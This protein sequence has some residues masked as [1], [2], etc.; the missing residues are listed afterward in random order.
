M[1]D[2][3][4][5][6]RGARDYD[7][8]DVVEVDSVTAGLIGREQ[9]CMEIA[10]LVDD[11]RG[12]RSGALVVR[13][14]PGIGKSA[15]LDYAGGLAAEMIVLRAV[16]VDSES[17]LAFAGLFGLVR[18]VLDLLD[19]LVETQARALAGALGM[20]A[21]PGI[22]RFLVGAAA[23]SLLAA[24]AEER[25]VLCL[26][27]DA[28]WLDRPSVDALSFA[29]RRLGADPIAMMFGAREGELRR[30]EGAGLPELVLTGLDHAAAGSLLCRHPREISPGVRDR[31]VAEA[32]G[33]PLALLELPS[34]LNDG[35][36]TGQESLPD[37]IPLTPRLEAL[38]RRRIE[39]LPPASQTAL[40]IA[41]ADNTGD[42]T[43]VSR[44]AGE[45]EL[46]TDALDPA[47]R[48]GLLST[49]E[50]TIAFRH[51][52]VRAAAYDAAALSERLRVH[53]ALAR[54]LSGDEDADRR[55]WHQAMATVTGNE[56]VA[57]AL[58]ASARRAQLR[59]GHASAATAFERAAALTLDDSR[60][61]PRLAA[62]AQAAWD[63]GQANRARELIARALPGAGGML[64]A[65]LLHLRGVI[66]P[67]RGSTRDGVRTLTD[68]AGASTDPS[69]TLEVLHDAIDSALDIGD[70]S[71]VRKLGE[72]A[73]GLPA[74]TPR[75][76]FNKTSVIAFGA[77]S[78]GHLR[79]AR[80]VFGEAL[81]L[82]RGMDDPAGQ[83][84]ASHV[85]SLAIELGAGLSFATRAVELARSQGLMCLLP[86]AL[87]QQAAE[88]A[89]NSRFDEA[90]AAAEE[91]Y[92]LSVE[93]GQSLEVFLFETMARVE[94][95]CGRE[96]DAREHAQ[97]VI[98]LAQQDRA[99]S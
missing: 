40:L 12:G 81:E 7:L 63:A 38:F 96:A 52:L 54:V 70:H 28:H 3:T 82:A 89:R 8:E 41:A 35:Q 84:W 16:G 74:R 88:L 49:G 51:P 73:A 90:Y 78:A 75:D 53:A 23:L 60:R 69:F 10:A 80:E 64:R 72:L 43:A 94:A 58:D 14:E 61:G 19:R 39:Q 29:A 47:E 36:L 9:E 67:R 79:R 98:G 44:A 32:V 5:S 76:A 15:L 59:G 68:A 21:S 87:D 93:L 30:F 26:V 83:L 42:L 85:A 48:A 4:G 99:I 66:E 33:N 37:A 25:P 24:V 86:R 56:E 46:G 50:R 20:A 92:Q 31:L 27:D 62:A 34:G 13:G 6:R 71:A 95:I 55:L 65:R 1:R 11:A 22:D 91:G 97:Q 17:D 57:A 77:R 18:P 2:W 45:L